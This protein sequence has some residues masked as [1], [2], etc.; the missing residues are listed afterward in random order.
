MGTR[1]APWTC[2]IYRLNATLSFF[3]ASMLPTFSEIPTQFDP[4]QIAQPLSV[5]GVRT[6]TTNM[7]PVRK[8]F[9][10]N[11][12]KRTA[13][14]SVHAD[15][16]DPYNYR[17]IALDP[18]QFPDVSSFE[19]NL[20]ES[21]KKT[22]S[23]LGE[24]AIEAIP[25][26][27][28]LGFQS[29]TTEDIIAAYLPKNIQ[30]VRSFE[31]IGHIAHLNLREEHMP[32]RHLIG[33]IILAKNPSLR[34]VVTKVGN[35][36]TQF[37]TFD[38]EVI[39]GDDDT[40]A[41]VSEGGFRFQLDFRK[42]YWNSRLGTEHT[43]LALSFSCDVIVCDMMAGIGPFAIP[44]AR[45]VGCVVHAN[46]LNPDSYLYL[47]KNRELNKIP[48]HRLHTYNLDG[49]QFVQ[50]LVAQRI[51]FTHVIM[52]LPAS[53]YTFLPVFRGLY[54]E[55]FC[56]HEFPAPTR[57]TPSVTPA[58]AK[59]K[60]KKPLITEKT[61]SSWAKLPHN[62]PWIHCYGFSA[63]ADPCKDYLELVEKTIGCSLPGAQ[64][65]EVRDVSPHKRMILASFPLPLSVALNQETTENV[66][67]RTRS[68]SCDGDIEISPEKKSKITKD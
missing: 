52:N 38:M 19:K 65:K 24:G 4:A 30:A 13:L 66:T 46:D 37:R 9:A 21:Q 25:Y 67:K 43:D 45:K 29:F 11:L 35:I 63:A 32:Y 57:S 17:V 53:A 6:R 12:L 16:N 56:S 33:Q 58:D 10:P 34:T 49:A 36:H 7:G 27:V 2:L 68:P 55:E 62:L 42:V 28:T 23:A 61:E 18:E 64:V 1:I 15:E 31:S 5:V 39:A 54:T 51:P 44:A 22:L 47:T 59:K 14:K 8:C 50:Q 20:T 41:T 48:K 3:P 60:K 40:V 26:T